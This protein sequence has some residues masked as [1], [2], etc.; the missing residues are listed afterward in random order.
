MLFLSLA[1]AL[2]GFGLM[3]DRALV[4][5]SAASAE[6][7]SAR[8]GPDARAAALSVRGALAGVEQ[9]LLA[10][11]SPAGVRQETLALSAGLSVSVGRPYRGRPLAEL[12]RLLLSTEATASGLPEAVIAA[13]ALGAATSRPE[14][15]ERL[16]TGQLPVRP[17]DLPQLAGLLGA[18]ADPRVPDLQRRLQDVPN[19]S[20]LP[21]AP[22]FQRRLAAAAAVEGWT[23]LGRSSLRYEVPLPALFERA[24]VADR[25]RLATG[26]G[27]AGASASVPDVDGLVLAMAPPAAPRG[28][29]LAARGLLWLAVVGCLLALALVRRAVAREASSVRREK[30]FLSGVTH[31]LRTPVAS[32]RVFGEALAAGAGDPREYGVLLVE[33]SRRLEALVERTLASARVDEAP[34]FVSV[35]PGELLHSVVEIMRP[36]AD[37]R[38]VTLHVHAD[39]AVGEVCWDADAVRRALLNLIEN[40]IKHGRSNGRV[41]AGAHADGGNVRL[42]VEDDGP[43]IGRREHRRLFGRFERGAT[44]APGAGL[45]LYLV[46]QVANAHGGRVDLTSEEGQGCTFTLVL[47]RLPS[48]HE[49]ARRP[50]PDA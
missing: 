38:G 32:I 42:S 26:S 36:A 31:E 5:E 16:L 48:A 24:G 12:R 45:G 4:R 41:E 27:A 30:A 47:P 19:P 35:R 20:D 25:A 2:S 6:L 29:L 49:A 37:R 3:A 23:R 10:G 17:E 22:A 18:S 7:S 13:V 44:E 14:V 8:A 43:G 39:E 21:R 33:E 15:V 40:A 11:R 34:K 9:D 1:G 28:R 50:E 46:D